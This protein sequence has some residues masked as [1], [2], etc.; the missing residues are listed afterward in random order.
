MLKAIQLRGGR[1]SIDFVKGLT[2]EEKIGDKYNYPNEQCCPK[3]KSTEVQAFYFSY[4]PTV[5]ECLKCGYVWEMP[6]QSSAF[7]RACGKFKRM[8]QGNLDY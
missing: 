5:L 6:Y 8:M 3:C 2:K 4:N 1:M 7:K